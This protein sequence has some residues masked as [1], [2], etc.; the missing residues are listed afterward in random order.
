MNKLSLVPSNSTTGLPAPFMMFDRFRVV[1]A[2]PNKTD[3]CRLWTHRFSTLHDKISK[4]L[5]HLS[6][7]SKLPGVRCQITAGRMIA[8]GTVFFDPRNL[9]A[10]LEVYVGGVARVVLTGIPTKQ[11]KW[12]GRDTLSAYWLPE[13]F[14]NSLPHHDLDTAIRSADWVLETT[15]RALQHPKTVSY[16]RLGNLLTIEVTP[17]ELRPAESTGLEPF[18]YGLSLVR[19]DSLMPQALTAAATVPQKRIGAQAWKQL[20]NPHWCIQRPALLGLDSDPELLPAAVSATDIAPRIGLCFRTGMGRL[21]PTRLVRKSRKRRRAGP[22]LVIGPAYKTKNC[23]GKLVVKRRS[24]T[25]VLYRKDEHLKTAP[26]KDANER[27]AKVFQSI[28]VTD[29]H[30]LPRMDAEISRPGWKRLGLSRLKDVRGLTPQEHARHVLSMLTVKPVRKL[31]D[32][33][34]ILGRQ[35]RKIDRS[36][37]EELCALHRIVMLAFIQFAIAAGSSVC[38]AD[39]VRFSD[40]LTVLGTRG[41]RYGMTGVSKFFRDAWR[42]LATKFVDGGLSMPATLKNAWDNG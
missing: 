34:K 27:Y 12:S 17:F 6:T 38:N 10:N 15:L 26:T 31:R 19:T 29:D 8:S 21:T 37:L 11:T 35:V 4:A 3:K 41:N 42:G 22:Y 2:A 33:E 14:V 13:Q 39:A 7:R 9:S 40:A 30:Q 24:Y 25:I 23:K 18:D 32:V 28:G 5:E 20:L 16:D 36:I 1:G